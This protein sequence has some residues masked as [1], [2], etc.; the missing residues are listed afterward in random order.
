[1]GKKTQTRLTDG[2]RDHIMGTQSDEPSTFSQQG[3]K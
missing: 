2:V 3:L 1:M